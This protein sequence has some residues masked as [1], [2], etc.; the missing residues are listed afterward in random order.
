M[1]RE[2]PIIQAATQCANEY[3]GGS[4]VLYAFKKG[5]EWADK[6][7]KSPWIS[8]EERLPNLYDSYYVHTKEGCCGI[9]FFAFGEFSKEETTDGEVDYWMPIPELPKGG[10]Q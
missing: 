9:A 4:L 6:H 5:A 8:V 7:P 10:E 2:E 1:T 3:A